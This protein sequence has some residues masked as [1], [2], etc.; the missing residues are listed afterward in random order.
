MQNKSFEREL[1][2]FFMVS[3]LSLLKSKAL[4]RGGYL[5]GNSML[6][7]DTRLPIKQYGVG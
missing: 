6:S 5:I 4:R 7:A 1:V 3:G 2:N